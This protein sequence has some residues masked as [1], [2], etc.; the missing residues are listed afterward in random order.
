MCRVQ[1]SESMDGWVWGFVG[2]DGL[3]SRA[4]YGIQT[5]RFDFWFNG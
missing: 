1:D 2:L 4:L 5:L 3:S